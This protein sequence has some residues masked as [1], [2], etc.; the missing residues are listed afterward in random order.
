MPSARAAKKLEHARDRSRCARRERA[1]AEALDRAGDAAHRG[2]CRRSG[3]M[4][5]L[6]AGAEAEREHTLLADADHRR[7]SAYER[8][9]GRHDGTALVE[10]EPWLDAAVP[11]RLGDHAR[12]PAERLLVA[13]ERQVHVARRREAGREEVLDGIHHH[14]QRSLVIEGATTVDPAVL[15]ASVEGRMGPGVA[16]VHGNDVEVRHEHGGPPRGASTPAVQDAELAD[17]LPL[18]ALVRERVELDEKIRERVERTLPTLGALGGHRGQ[19]DHARQPLR[20]ARADAHGSPGWGVRRS[21]SAVLVAFRLG[22]ASSLNDREGRP[23]IGRRSAPRR[24]P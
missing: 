13:A 7:T 24:R 12:G 9:R 11:Q 1:G 2:A 19:L 3:R 16:L 14:H 4:P 15:D 22:R 21:V 18:Q 10:H 20:D 6:A 17:A 23:L 5:A 8:E